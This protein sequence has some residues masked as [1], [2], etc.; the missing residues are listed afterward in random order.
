MKLHKTICAGV[1]FVAALAF[2]T[3]APADSSTIEGVRNFHKVDDRVYRGAQPTSEGFRNLAKLG[4]KIVV[5]LREGG[6]RSLN[7]EKLVAADGMRYV[8]FP[9]NGWGAP[10]L[11]NVTKVLDLLEDASTGPVFVHC[12]RGADRTGSV[13]ACYRVEHDR[14]RNAQALAEARSLG[15]SRLEKGMQHFVL[16]YLPRL[17]AP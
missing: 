12:K 8:A 13:I 14:W 17:P 10:T 4:V 15:M 5:D 6:G 7:E 2:A 11:A 16:D 1:A 9:L 3:A